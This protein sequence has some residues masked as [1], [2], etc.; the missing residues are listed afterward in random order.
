[1]SYHIKTYLVRP[2]YPDLSDNRPG[3]QGGC[4]LLR[5][6]PQGTVCSP[7]SDTAGSGQLHSGC[8][9]TLL[10]GPKVVPIQPEIEWSGVQS[11]LSELTLLTLLCDVQEI[12]KTVVAE[13]SAR[14][15]RNSAKFG[16]NFHPRFMRQIIDNFNCIL[17]RF[18][19]IWKATF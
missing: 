11:G 17:H 2:F 8:Q 12:H 4:T 7:R 18:F 9:G 15:P 13:I 10:L 16:D 14:S 19:I 6:P 3:W 1:M 5:R